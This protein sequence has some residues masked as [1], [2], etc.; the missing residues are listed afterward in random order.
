MLIISK[1]WGGVL[2]FGFPFVIGMAIW[3]AGP[4]MA[5]NL[6]FGIALLSSALPIWFSGR[7]LNVKKET[8]V[9]PKTGE[10]TESSPHTLFF[11]PIEYW[12]VLSLLAGLYLTFLF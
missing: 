6:S 2:V 8:R 5:D 12:A 9:D 11:V 3:L 4:E 7:K 1:G 10:K